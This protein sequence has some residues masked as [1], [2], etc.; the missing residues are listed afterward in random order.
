MESHDGAKQRGLSNT[1][2]SQQRDGLA[3][4]QAQVDF[5]E[6]AAHPVGAGYAFKSKHSA[7]PVLAQDRWRLPRDPSEP[8][9]NCLPSASAPDARLLPT[10]P[11]VPRRPC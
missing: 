5:V 2:P 8:P 6:Y 7:A 10:L 11:V 9:R 4:T 3:V 1:I